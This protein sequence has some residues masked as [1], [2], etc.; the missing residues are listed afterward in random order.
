MK[1]KFIPLLL[2]GV[3]SLGLSGCVINVGED[4]HDNGWNGSSWKSEENRNRELI[5]NLTPGVAI[6]EIKTRMG[7]ADFSEAYSKDNGLVEVLFYRTQRVHGDGKTSKDECT[8]LVFKQGKLVGWGD[9]AY[10]SI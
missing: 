3:V 1:A 5:S 2:A 4:G 10:N 8:A 9:R 6:E 7:T